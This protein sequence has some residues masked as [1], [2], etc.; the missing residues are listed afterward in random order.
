MEVVT[1]N[2][3]IKAE[4][5]LESVTP[6]FPT[7]FKEELNAYSFQLY[8]QRNNPNVRKQA[9]IKLMTFAADLANGINMTSDQYDRRI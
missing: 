9:V 6:N 8:D 3:L 4:L 7:I 5:S 1:K 2:P